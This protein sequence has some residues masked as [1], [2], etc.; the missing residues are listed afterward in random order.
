MADIPETRY[1]RSGDVHVAYQVFGAGP[2][3]VSVPGIATHRD[4]AWELPSFAYGLRRRAE[5]ARVIAF[6]KRGTGLSD[7][8]PAP[9]LEQRMD[10]V[11]A[12]MDAVG[13][14]RAVIEGNSEG[15]PLAVLFAAT[16]PHRTEA[17]I[18]NGSFARLV[19]DDDIPWGIPPAAV[20]DTVEALTSMW[21]TGQFIINALGF[22][23]DPAWAGRA[24]RYSASPANFRA[25]L[26]MTMEVDV[27]DVL[28]T[29]QVPTLVIHHTDD[30]AIPVQ[31]GRYLADRIPGAGYV[32]FAGGHLTSISDAAD[33]VFDEIEE[34]V[35]GVRR[36]P[37][38]DRMLTTVLFTDIVRSTE[39]AATVG[40]RG[41]RELLDRHDDISARLV[42]EFRGRLV[43]STGDGLLATFD[44]PGRAVECAAALCGNVRRLGLELRAGVHTGEVEIRGDDIGGIAVHIGARIVAEAGASEVLASRVVRDLVVGS[45][46]SFE[47]RGCY[48]LKGV[49]DEWELFAAVV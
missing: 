44:G 25:L 43:K 30:Q 46:I 15:G 16:Y 1:A 23:G 28:P 6:D 18:L 8:A 9:T 35:T 34:F 47:R 11:R 12:V 24:E 37:A 19:Q 33:A 41:W 40:D 38:P 29:I 13:S 20:D 17:L 27:R 49:P 32:E 26:R 48:A 4:L 3:Y 21:G 45:S 2:D 10:D 22:D 7:P 36:R 39:Q 5:F 42:D 14:D 31:H